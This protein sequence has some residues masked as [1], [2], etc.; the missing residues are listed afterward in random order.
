MS[1]H[2]PPAKLA[3]DIATSSDNI[4][5]GTWSVEPRATFSTP[6]SQNQ[7]PNFGL[8]VAAR[9]CSVEDPICVPNFDANYQTRTMWNS[10]FNLNA[11]NICPKTVP[12]LVAHVLPGCVHYEMIFVLIV[13]IKSLSTRRDFGQGVFG[14]FAFWMR[15]VPQVGCEYR[16]A[17]PIVTSR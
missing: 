12:E 14:P 4:P 1:Q 15:Q 2:S 8:N 9:K 7:T 6:T 16:H 11:G 17:A 3:C 13:E 5:P 10:T